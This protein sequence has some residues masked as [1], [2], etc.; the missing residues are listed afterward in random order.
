M[1]L[2]IGELMPAEPE[3]TIAALDQLTAGMPGLVPRRRL[4]GLS[5][6][7]TDAGRSWRDGTPVE[8]S[9]NDLLMAV[10]G[11]PFVLDR[12]AGPGVPV[13]AQR[14]SG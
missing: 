4:R 3:V 13:L 10:A 12:L 6:V 8:G 1:R 14:L 9:L 5:L 7:T 2:P 11:R